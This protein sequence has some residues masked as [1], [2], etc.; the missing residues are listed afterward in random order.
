[1]VAPFHFDR[2]FELPVAPAELW[3][4]LTRTDDY[5]RWWPWLRVCDA[6]G[7][8]V[9]TC[10]RCEI[11]APLPYRLRCRVRVERV[12][13]ARAL[14]AT[15]TGD[16]HGPARLE[17]RP[18]PEGSRARLTWALELRA[19]V[20]GRLVPI[21]RPAMAW[22]HDAVVTAGLVQF[23][24]RALGGHSP[25]STLPGDPPKHQVCPGG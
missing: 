16:L 20:L 5:S 11:R 10:A 22:A 2:A 13:P 9:G 6:D 24:T 4:V 15:V 25:R 23:R 14:D 19:P 7:L 3:A 12:E 1:M 17:V 18:S 8:T 21:T